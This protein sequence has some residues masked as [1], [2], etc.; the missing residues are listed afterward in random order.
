M[1][2]NEIA[3][4]LDPSGITSAVAA[5]LVREMILLYG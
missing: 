5:K 4:P 3:P 2:I 1:D